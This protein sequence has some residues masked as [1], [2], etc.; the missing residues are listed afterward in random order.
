MPVIAV[1]LIEGRTDEQ[2]EALIAG[3]TEAAVA[4]LGAPA[5]SV[6]VLLNEIPPSHWGV[7]G[8][9]KLQ[10]ANGGNPS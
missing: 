7:G 4:A 9:S 2:L 8:V 6:R 1:S 3:L 5:A 10:Q